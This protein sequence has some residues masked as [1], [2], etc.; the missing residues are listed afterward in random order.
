MEINEK[1]LSNCL[2]DERSVLSPG[3]GIFAK[4][5]GLHNMLYT[6]HIHFFFTRNEC[7]ADLYFDFFLF[8]MR[9]TKHPPLHLSRFLLQVSC[10]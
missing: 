4:Q 7:N 10:V 6:L 9:A 3:Y 2:N 5:S 8:C 1:S